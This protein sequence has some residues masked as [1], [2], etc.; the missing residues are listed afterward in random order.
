MHW[1]GCPQQSLQFSRGK[2]KNKPMDN[3]GFQWLCLIWFSW[4]VESESEYIIMWVTAERQ[5]KE[6]HRKDTRWHD[7]VAV[8]V[9][10]RVCGCGC[11]GECCQPGYID[12]WMDV[13]GCGLHREMW[14][15][16]K[17]AAT[18]RFQISC[19]KDFDTDVIAMPF[20]ESL[21]FSRCL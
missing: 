10:G 1:M 5:R 14:T 2:L 18:S 9:C 12:E 17:G 4:T 3:A 16:S 21:F 8:L 19:R 6:V 13:F 7:V 11:G 15:R 20:P